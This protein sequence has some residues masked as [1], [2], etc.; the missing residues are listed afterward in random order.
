MSFSST[1]TYD[2]ELDRRT[3]DCDDEFVGVLVCDGS[4]NGPSEP[5]QAPTDEQIRVRAAVVVDGRRW[6]A[7]WYPQ[8]GGY[9]VKCWVGIDLTE[10][11]RESGCFECLVWHDGDFPLTDNSNP[12]RLHHCDPNQFILFGE[13]V[14]DEIAKAST[15]QP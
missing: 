6:I 8:I 5:L 11:G 12:V 2:D 9:T 15:C 13:M 10:G 4:T 7:S 1:R 14:K 3:I